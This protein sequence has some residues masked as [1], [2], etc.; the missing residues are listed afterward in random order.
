MSL[1][2]LEHPGVYYVDK[3]IQ[4]QKQIS[5]MVG[6]GSGPISGFGWFAGDCLNIYLKYKN[7]L[8]KVKI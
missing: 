6:T 1:V 3:I 2:G 7:V 4:A 5:D 8:W